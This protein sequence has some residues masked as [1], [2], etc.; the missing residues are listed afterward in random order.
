VARLLSLTF[1]DGPDP[2]WTT[3]VLDALQRSRTRATFFMVG[4]RVLTT[5]A[6]ARAVVEAG[7]DVQL[8]CHRHIRH[9]EL[10][11]PAIERD[12]CDALAALELIGARPT[13]WRTPWGVRTPASVRVAGTHRLRLVNWTHDTHDWRGDA[14]AAMLAAA[15]PAL[16]E[17]GVVLMHDGLGP[18][19]LRQG[20]EN[21]VELVAVLAD[22]ARREA[23]SVGPLSL[24]APDTVADARASQIVRAGGG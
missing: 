19:S 21:T 22:A 20:C 24:Q 1:D 15:A 13:L 3:R 18:G 14:S 17:G 10:S 8:H 7:H 2:V 9:T 5:P 4:E 16:A 11:E 23:L 6:T 12:A